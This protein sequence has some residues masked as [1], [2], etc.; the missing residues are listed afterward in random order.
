MTNGDAERRSK[1]RMGLGRKWTNLL[2]VTDSPAVRDRIIRNSTPTQLLI[3]AILWSAGVIAFTVTIFVEQ[4]KGLVWFL[5]CDVLW[6]WLAVISWIHWG[7]Y[8]HQRDPVER[9]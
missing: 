2:G 7:R 6:V 4:P 9:G 5:V 8:R 1:D 3:T